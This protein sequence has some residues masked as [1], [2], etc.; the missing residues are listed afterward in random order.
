MLTT[1]KIIA[2]MK[3]K[4]IRRTRRSE[5]LQTARHQSQKTLKKRVPKNWKRNPTLFGKSFAKICPNLRKQMTQMFRPIHPLMTVP[6]RLWLLRLMI[7]L[8]KKWK[9]PK[10][11][12][13]V[14]NP[15]STRMIIITIIMIIKIPK[16][17]LQRQLNGSEASEMSW[18]S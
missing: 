17:V 7:L 9:S 2:Q 1:V 6:Q 12:Q 14:L 15:G 4:A 5:R 11:L 3:K 13:T 10:K 18:V 16:E 8:V